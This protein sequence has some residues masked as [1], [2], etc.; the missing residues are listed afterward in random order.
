MH[1]APIAIFAFNRPDHLRQT[2]TALADNNLAAESDITIFCDGPRNVEEAVLTE[3]VRSVAKGAKGFRSV[4]VTG[5][6]QNLGCARAVMSG[7]VE[8][9]ARHERLIVIEDDILCSPHTLSFLNTCLEKYAT[10]STVFSIAAWAP[11]LNLAAIPKEYPYDIYFTP[12][13]HCWGWASWRDRLEKVDWNVSDYGEFKRQPY[14]QRAF[15]QGGEDLSPMLVEQM[16]GGLDT[17]DIQMDYS[18]FKHGC[19]GVN[20]VYS[21][22]TNIG[23]GSGTHTTVPTAVFDN[24]LTLAVASPKLPD[25]IFMDQDIVAIRR[26]AFSPASFWRRL[27]GKISRLLGRKA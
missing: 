9:T 24:D 5:R 12:R 7:L 8:M 6:E 3:A 26:K 15:C 13:F 21:Y 2:L 18:R 22:T 14:L 10:A 23:M 4:T 19:V 17:W 16:E 20:P 11:P 25:H 27:A 1:V